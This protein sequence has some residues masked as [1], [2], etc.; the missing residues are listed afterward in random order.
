VRVGAGGRCR[1]QGA[2][3]VAVLWL[4]GLPVGRWPAWCACPV[5]SASPC[6]GDSSTAHPIQLSKTIMKAWHANCNTHKTCLIVLIYFEARQVAR[7]DHTR[8]ATLP[9]SPP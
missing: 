2:Y 3:L 6:P 4:A 1:G 7:Y 9:D 5:A 8:A